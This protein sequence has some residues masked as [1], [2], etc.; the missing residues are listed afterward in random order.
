MG[1]GDRSQLVSAAY[2]MM[3]LLEVS[4]RAQ[5]GVQISSKRM[6]IH[7]KNRGGKKMQVGSMFKKGG[8]GVKGTM[9][10]V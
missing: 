1:N 8:K 4:K 6:G 10:N 7:P 2:K 5:R 3:K 9:N